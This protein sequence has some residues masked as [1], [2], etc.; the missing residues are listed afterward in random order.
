MTGHGRAEVYARGK[1]W[2]HRVPR[3]GA[4]GWFFGV[5]RGRVG[6]GGGA[7]APAAG[8]GRYSST[9]AAAGKNMGR[10]TVRTRS[11]KPFYVYFRILHA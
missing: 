4:A 5:R 6:R 2:P 3:V 9:Q 11:K 7:I 10:W 1:F 8:V